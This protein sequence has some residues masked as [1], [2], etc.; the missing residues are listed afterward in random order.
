MRKVALVSVIAIAALLV[1]P[2]CHA[3]STGE[4]IKIERVEINIS[5]GDVSEHL[6]FSSTADYNGTLKF[7]M[8]SDKYSVEYMGN[9]LTGTPDGNVLTI[10]LGGHNLT[11]PA[12]G[13]ISVNV[14]YTIKDRFEYR[15]N[16]PTEEMDITVNSGKYPRGNI[17]IKYEGNGIYTS[18]LASLQENDSFWIEFVGETSRGGAVSIST[19][20]GA[21]AVLLALAIIVFILKK[22]GAD[23]TLGKESV[24]AL[25]L[26]KRLLTDSLKTLEI[27]HEKKKIP[28]AYYR[29]IKE[30]FKKE[31]IKVM[32]E[33]D[34]RT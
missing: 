13:N 27:E 24:E 28:D 15:V 29:S 20:A 5:E 33:I 11:I 8:P 14:N 19:L 31:A 22:R 10:D 3:A 6:W 34:R 18:N 25:E 4:S 21:I 7:W 1:I 23:S 2:Y 32:R 12:G 26:R 16:Y 17:P 30:Y 9:Q